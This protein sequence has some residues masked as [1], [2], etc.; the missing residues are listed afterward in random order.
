M[1]AKSVVVGLL[2]IAAVAEAS[3]IRG[4]FDQVLGRRA[5]RTLAVRQNNNG[6]NNNNNNGGNNNNNNGGNGGNNG[7]N[8]GGDASETCL[9][10][11]ALQT[12]SQN[13]GLANAADG[14]A[15]SATDN[16]NF[17]NF[18][19]GQTLTNG[20]QQ[21]QGSCNGI[22]MGKMP[23][24]DRMVSAILQNPQHNDNLEEN[25]DFD[26]QIQ[27]ANL[28][29]GTFTNP[30]ETYYAAPQD[31][32]GSGQVIGHTHV[33]IQDLGNS[34]N[35][36]QALDATQFAFFKGINDAGNG[37][38]LLSATVTGGLPAGNYRVCSMTGAGNHQ[39][40]LMPVAQRGAQDD[41]NKFTVGAANNDG[42]DDQQQDDDQAQDDQTQD[43]QT[44]DDQTQDDQTQDDQTQDD[45]NQGQGQGQG[46]FG[47]GFGGG[48]GGGFGGGNTGSFST[49][50][51]T[52]TVPTSS[53][54]ST[55]SASTQTNDASS[56]GSEA[57][58]NRTGTGSRQAIG[59]ITAPAVEDSGNPDRPFSVNGNTFVNKS[60]AIE[61]AC[62]IQN[63]ACADAVNGGKVTGFSVSDCFAQISTCEASL[64]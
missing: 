36:T 1:L 44:Q 64:S 3:V 5:T 32:D 56:D 42:T 9:S 51:S 58:D 18:C 2:S 61:R 38:G 16:A 8:N 40:V 19:D 47:G 55:A 62:A 15:A 31:L 35:P 21:S 29:A 6:G 53:S 27:M 30:D 34:M 11:T 7:G 12:G 33:V 17:I 63:N 14:Q 13:D 10:A 45:Q 54:T 23:S 41:C 43:D 59:G 25:Q 20:L 37:N 24:Q 60:A 57:N 50:T 4:P 26:I 22:V 48:Q 52:S 39:P 28:A 46:G 49:S